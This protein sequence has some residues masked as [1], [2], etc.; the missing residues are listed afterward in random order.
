MDAFS[1]VKGVTLFNFHRQNKDIKPYVV[2][3][4]IFMYINLVYYTKVNGEEFSLFYMF[5]FLTGI[6]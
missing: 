2:L 4:T 1:N 5:N 3:L 6:N